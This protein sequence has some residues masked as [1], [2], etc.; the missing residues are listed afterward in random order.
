MERNGGLYVTNPMTGLWKQIGKAD[1]GRIQFIFGV[2]GSLYSIEDGDLY[3]INTTTGNRTT[4]KS[5]PQSTAAIQN[6]ER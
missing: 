3:L 6:R 1:F 4:V 5:I 2:G